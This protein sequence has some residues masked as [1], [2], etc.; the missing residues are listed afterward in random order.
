L[1]DAMDLRNN[2]ITSKVE[3]QCL[4]HVL[5]IANYKNEEK[6]LN[7]G[8]FFF[9]SNPSKKYKINFNLIEFC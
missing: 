7:R 4:N 9:S 6:D 8:R 1:K 3:A 5:Q 2:L